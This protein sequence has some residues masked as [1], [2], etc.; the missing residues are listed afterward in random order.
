MKLV[1][2]SLVAIVLLLLVPWTIVRFGVPTKIQKPEPVSPISVSSY[3]IS[4][5]YNLNE[6]AAVQRYGDAALAVSGEIIKLTMDFDGDPVVELEGSDRNS[7][8]RAYF[9]QESAESLSALTKGNLI[10]ILCTDLEKGI[11]GPS[12]TGCSLSAH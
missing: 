7:T 12:L 6:I 10:D 8:V 2:L 1:A 4:S 3:E 11:F 5:L 9:T